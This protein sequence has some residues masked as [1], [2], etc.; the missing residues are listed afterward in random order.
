MVKT[1]RDDGSAEAAEQA[2]GEQS[3]EANEISA[4][5]KYSFTGR[6]L[7]A[8]GGLLP[9]AAMLNKVE[10]RELVGTAV[11]LELK[12]MPRAMSPSDFLPGRVSWL[13]PVE[14]SAVSGAGA[15]VGGDLAV[16]PL[17]GVEHLLAF[18]V[19]VAFERGTAV[20]AAE[21]RFAGTGLGGR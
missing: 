18:S 11:N 7:T 8:Y 9:V 13:L 12:R 10:L 20:G 6:N 21:R 19:F 2:R 1:D 14:P 16:D 5:T 3:R 4:A 17:A 15:D